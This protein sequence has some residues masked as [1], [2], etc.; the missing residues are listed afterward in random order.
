[1]RVPTRGKPLGSDV[2][3]PMIAR[4]TAGLTGADLAN[5]ANEAAIFAGRENLEYVTQ[6]NFDAAME[7]VVAGLQK[8]RVV[9]EKEKRVL[10]FHEAGHALMS[11]LMGELMPLQKVSS[12]GRGDALGYA[13]SLPTE[14]RYD[15]PKEQLA[16][17][18]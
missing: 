5:L 7:R 1:M 15:R 16:D 11:Y 4:Q 8:R 18:M 17:W 2:D 14:D 9:S 13:S 6:E 10:A 12:V 3:L